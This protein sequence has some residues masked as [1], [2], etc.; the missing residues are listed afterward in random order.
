MERLRFKFTIDNHTTTEQLDP[1][2]CIG[3]NVEHTVTLNHGINHIVFDDYVNH[4]GVSILQLKILEQGEFSYLIGEFSIKN[5]TINGSDIFSS[6]YES[7]YYPNYDDHDE[8][9][10][11]DSV[12][13]LGNRGIWVWP[14]V[15]PIYNNEK[16]KIGLW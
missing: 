5:I 12:T 2:I 10:C 15:T 3:V 1:I 9:C 13:T 11:L 8:L 6:I 16:L 7:K 14:F 4:A